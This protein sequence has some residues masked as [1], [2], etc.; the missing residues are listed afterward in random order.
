MGGVRDFLGIG[1]KTAGMDHQINIQ[2]FGKCRALVERNQVVAGGFGILVFHIAFGME[3]LDNPGLYHK[4]W[5][6]VLED[7]ARQQEINRDIAK[8]IAHIRTCKTNTINSET[9]Y[10]TEN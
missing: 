3:Y 7:Q 9:V 2:N 8:P 6:C 4:K 1:K 10:E 5:H